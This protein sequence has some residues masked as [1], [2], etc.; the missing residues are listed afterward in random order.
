MACQGAILHKQKARF[1]RLTLQMLLHR[2]VV[3]LFK[4]T[5]ALH[6]VVVLETTQLDYK[7]ALF[8]SNSSVVLHYG[9]LNY[10]S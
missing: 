6:G 2:L 3:K 10:T 9:I 1:G 8:G 4:T 7:Q 5:S